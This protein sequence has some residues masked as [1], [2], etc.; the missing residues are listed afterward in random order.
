MLAYWQAWSIFNVV[1]SCK[2]HLNFSSPISTDSFLPK[3]MWDLSDS[4]GEKTVEDVLGKQNKTKVA[5]T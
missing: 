1:S 4:C 5:Y 3:S 2:W